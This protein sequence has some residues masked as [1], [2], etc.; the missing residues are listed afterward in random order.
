MASTPRR[1]FLASPSKGSV[2]GVDS[3]VASCS[4]DNMGSNSLPVFSPLPISLIASPIG[5]V[6]IIW[7]GSG[8]I[9][10]RRITFGLIS[11]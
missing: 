4:M 2:S 7:T 1:K 8:N 9:G 3:R 10:P 11:E 5:I 6:V